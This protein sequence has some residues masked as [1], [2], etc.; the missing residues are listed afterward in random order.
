MKKI[1]LLLIL[2]PFFTLAQDR[3]HGGGR[4][5]NFKGFG[6][7]NSKDYI[8]GNIGGK[9]L[10]SK[11][12]DPL[13]FA[14][15]S[16]TNTRWS[17]I[18]E[19]T[20]T[21]EKG[22]FF[23]NKIRSGKY[24]IS[25]SFIGYEPQEIDFELTKRKPDVKLDNILMI[26]NN[27]M[28]SEVKISEQ[29][30]I[31]ENKIDKIVY[32]AEHDMN[33]GLIDATDVLRKAPL[34]TV[35][36]EGEVS[37]R[38]SK[39]IKFLINGKASAFFNSDIATA[40]QMIPADEIKAIEIITSPGAKY[41]GEGDA[42]IVNIITK[43][44]IIDGYKSTINTALGTRVN[45]QSV[46]LSIGKGRF[47]LSARGGAHY[48]WP[49]KGTANLIRK[50]W[51]EINE[52]DTT[53]LSKLT[54]NSN[55]FGQWIGYRGSINMFYDINAYNNIMS[56]IR[57]NGRNSYS[58]DSTTYNM[59]REDSNYKY[60]SYIETNSS[61]NRIEWS[62]DY[63][64]TFADNEERELAISFQIG[65][66]LGDDDIDNFKDKVKQYHNANDEKEIEST[67]QLDYIHPF[68]E[69]NKIEIGGKFINRDRE[70]VYSNTSSLERYVAPQETFNYSQKVLAAYLSSDWVLP[71]DFGI[72]AGIRFEQTQISGDWESGEKDPFNSS[73]ISILPSVAIAKK[74]GD[75]KSF[76]ISYNKRISRP[77]TKHINPNTLNTDN[78]SVTIGNPDLSP[79][80]TQQIEMGYNSFGK[81]YQGSYYVYA[82]HTKDIV[83]AYRSMVDS[84]IFQTEFK[85][86]G[87][88]TTYGL[89]YFGSLRYDK[90]NLRAGFNLYQYKG[91]ATINNE[92]ISL[93]SNLL[94]SYNFG[95]M[96][97]LGKRWK[98]ESWAFFRSPSQ[99]IQGTSTSFSMM[100]FGVK[101][102]FKNKR[103]SVGLHV[104]EPFNKYKVF[105]SDMKGENFTYQSDR[106]IA[107][108]SFGF[109]FQY[110]FGKLNFKA[111]SKQSNIKNDDVQQDS[112]EEF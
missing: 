111:A 85:N 6:K 49:R 92:Y 89:N 106:S 61:V 110:T 38:G 63:T 31:Y 73:Y 103:G 56:D 25:I 97:D 45:R 76:K 108:R 26:A 12:G 19:G 62:T 54:K 74:F 1:L 13:E 43:K 87:N 29:K 94:Y 23:M 42:G 5:G 35:D 68:W 70:M 32:N 36:L 69:E 100:S 71:A 65:G 112:G 27:E 15:I 86:I 107:F 14:N 10:D 22:K 37:L 44:K 109:N 9:V 33:E 16:L 21:D 96:Y 78:Y 66:H 91:N 11:T 99:T 67:L 8:K 3:G 17:K 18:V 102:S 46:N 81:R 58:Y 75:A 77:R 39:N 88:S 47:G 30:P 4:G 48:G 52:N 28:L 83:E 34:L 24:Q 60:A 53:Y 72:K 2:I 93:T 51:S 57:I 104:I 90:F 50:D 40:L 84:I 105:S 79:A 7:D 101:K 98:I 80:I 95:G 20:I 82:K 55:T 59:K 41:D 64:K